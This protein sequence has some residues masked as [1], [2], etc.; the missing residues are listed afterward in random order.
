MTLARNVVRK[1]AFLAVVFGGIGLLIAMFLG[2]ADVIGTQFNHPV[3]GALEVTQSTIVLIVFGGLT[4]AQI[5]HS[6]IRV[7]L[8]YLR[9]GPKLQSSMD[10][11]TL[12]MAIIFFALLAWQGYL[13]A[14]YSWEIGEATSGLVQFPLY[15]ARYVLTF[16]ACLFLVQLALDL[17][18][19][20]RHFG[21]PVKAEDELLP[22]E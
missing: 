18:T 3:P 1:L 8:F 4:F 14:E 2:V 10:I 16:G 20:I 21:A 9:A 17:I 22:I 5:R 11:V 6:H 19:A 15:P 12:T 7:E 13:E